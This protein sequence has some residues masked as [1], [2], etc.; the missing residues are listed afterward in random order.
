MYS[1]SGMQATP[2]H[3]GCNSEVEC[4]FLLSGAEMQ[5]ITIDPPF[6]TTIMINVQYPLNGRSDA[7]STYIRAT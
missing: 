5:F 6:Y 1:Y 7:I 3:L 2:V 4:I